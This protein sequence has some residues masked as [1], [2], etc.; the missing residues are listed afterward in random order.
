MTNPLTDM[1]ERAARAQRAI[2]RITDGTDP[3][4]PDDPELRM[5]LLHRHEATRD[6]ALNVIDGLLRHNLADMEDLA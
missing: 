6:A 1:R 2:D 3:D 5:S 4:L